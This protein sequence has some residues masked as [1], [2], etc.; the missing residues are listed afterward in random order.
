MLHCCQGTHVHEQYVSTGTGTLYVLRRVQETLGVLK[1]KK[2]KLYFKVDFL[3][4]VPTTI[5][6]WCSG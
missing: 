1:T 2:N 4:N 3:H 6:W 5:C